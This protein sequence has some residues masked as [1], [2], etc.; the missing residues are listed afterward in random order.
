MFISLLTVVVWRGE[1]DAKTIVWMQIFCLVFAETK[2]D[3]SRTISVFRALMWSAPL[4]PKCFMQL[5]VNAGEMYARCF[6][7]S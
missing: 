6:G 7:G 5:S 2:T 3:I 1:N 4:R